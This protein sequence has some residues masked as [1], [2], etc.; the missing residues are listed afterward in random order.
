MKARV[1]AAR[2]LGFLS[3]Y[4]VQPAPGVIYTPEIESPVDCYTKV[5]LGHLQSRSALQRLICG[6]IISFWALSDPSIKP[7]PPQL[8]EKLKYCVMEYV[9]YDEVA[10][11]FTR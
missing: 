1:N 6:M 11:S 4:L 10:L 3:Q 2:I 5:L 8:Q 9:Y 7:G